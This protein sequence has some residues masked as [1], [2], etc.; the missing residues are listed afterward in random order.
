[1]TKLD[2]AVE[3]CRDEAVLACSGDSTANGSSMLFNSIEFFS[4]N[5]FRWFV[6]DE[7]DN[8]WTQ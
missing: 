8:V 5:A 4:G 7:W 6:Y 1:M 3:C 2:P